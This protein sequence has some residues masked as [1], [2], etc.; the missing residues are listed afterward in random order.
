MA[1]TFN[2]TADIDGLCIFSVWLVAEW[3]GT[4]FHPAN[5]SPTYKIPE[6]SNVNSVL[7]P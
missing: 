2:T 4:I 5:Y 3:S 6:G 7:F 1:E